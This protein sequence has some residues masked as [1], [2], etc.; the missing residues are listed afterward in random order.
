VVGSPFA[1]RPFSGLWA[2]LRACPGV[3]TAILMMDAGVK[4]RIVR[5]GEG[6]TAVAVTDI[7]AFRID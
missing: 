5:A 3:E 7:R 6:M 2:Q 1:R 4:T